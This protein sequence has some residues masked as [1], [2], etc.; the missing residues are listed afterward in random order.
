MSLNH[1]QNEN[2]IKRKK[3]DEFPEN[4]SSITEFKRLALKYCKEND[5]QSFQ[6]NTDD[7]QELGIYCCFI[8]FDNNQ[9]FNWLYV[10]F[11]SL[12]YR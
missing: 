3:L 11:N 4:V 1:S 9:Y 7:F 2:S 8:C 6:S 10:K 5:I 12:E